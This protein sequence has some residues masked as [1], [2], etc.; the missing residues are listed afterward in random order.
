MRVPKSTLI[1]AFLS[2]ILAGATSFVIWYWI[3]SESVI[4]EVAGDTTIHLGVPGVG[5]S[6]E[7]GI[8]DARSA[9]LYD[10]GTDSILF[11]QNGFEPRPIASITKLMTFMVAA[12]LG[13]DWDRGVEILPTE[14][15]VGGNL[16]MHPGEQVTM[17]DL[18]GASLVGSANNA[19]IA[20]VREMNIPTEEFVQAMNRKAVE[21][22][23]E[24]TRFHDVTGLSNK[25]ISTA[26]EVARMAAAAFRDYP[27]VGELT[28][29]PGYDIT[30][31]GSGRVHTVKNS[32]K[33]IS[34]WGDS[35][36]GSKTGYI[37]EA[38]YCLVAR[39]SGLDTNR[40]S[41]ILG[42]PGETEHFVDTKKLL[43]LLE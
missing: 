20:Y 5:G 41:V 8:F 28:S 29:Q 38:G 6:T 30:Y 40:I 26:Y 11:Q 2:L 17:R 1:F 7:D 24:Q 32:N 23:L 14:Y 22:G 21:L 42:S 25:N 43:H 34:E 3:H 39:G 4:P 31:K 13:I 27:I 33:I 19:T 10:M 12:D 37:Y 35:L 36:G 9:L 15:V 18:V 16:L